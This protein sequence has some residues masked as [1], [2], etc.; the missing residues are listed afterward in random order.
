MPKTQR[1]VPASIL[2][3]RSRWQTKRDITPR[4]SRRGRNRYD[5]FDFPTGMELNLG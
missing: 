5:R 3:A 1:L 2:N 4:R